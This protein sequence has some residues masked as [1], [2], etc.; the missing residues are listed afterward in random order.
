MEN[1]EVARVWFQA[2]V[3]LMIFF[4]IM[5][6]R[7]QRKTKDWERHD[8]SDFLGLNLFMAFGTAMLAMCYAVL[9]D[10]F[11]WNAVRLIVGIA[12]TIG[13]KICIYKM[14]VEPKEEEKKGR[15]KR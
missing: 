12:A 8:L 15:K 14:W 3:T 11:R 13:L 6:V 5:Y 4:E 1:V 7:S 10:N 2:F 9:W